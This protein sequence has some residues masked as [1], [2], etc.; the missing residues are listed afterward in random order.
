MHSLMPIPVIPL[1][2][3]GDEREEVQ[4][5][6]FVD[7]HVPDTITVQIAPPPVEHYVDSSGIAPRYVENW[8]AFVG[9]EHIKDEVGVYIDAH[10]TNCE[11]LPHILLAATMPGSGKT[12]L[13]RCIADEIEQRI[14]ML[15][16]PF[17]PEALY[18]AAM[19][20]KE[21][22][23]LF[24]DEIHRLGEHGPAA[25]ENLLH[26]AEEHVLYLN[27]KVFKLEDFTLIGAT[28]DADKLPEAVLDRFPVQ[29]FFAP[30]SHADMVRIVH[31][32]CRYYNVT[33]LPQTMVVL[34]KASRGTPRIARGLVEGA[35]ALQTARGRSVTGEEVLAWKRIDADGMTRQ[36]KNYV[37]VM[38]QLC[39]QRE[40]DGIVY[41]AGEETIGTLLR[42]G[43]RGV[44]RIERY[45]IEQGYIIKS[46][47]GRVLT[48]RGIRAARQYETEGIR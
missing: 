35:K 11:R 26:M 48:E 43:K 33:L 4:R 44:S 6:T 38:Y 34:A 40:K 21:F 29:P 28:T 23:I 32:F 13:A 37:L 22:E 19:S 31:N 7:V 41:R 10:F 36:H 2:L 17:K 12:T 20:M 24:I 45:L 42:E 5:D 46:G 27:G 15:V 8:D 16:P 1:S 39:G 30:Y 3:F 14:V 18:E 9:Q 25:A 47:R